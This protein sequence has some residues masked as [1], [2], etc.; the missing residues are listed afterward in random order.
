MVQF[1]LESD[2]TNEP[3]LLCTFKERLDTA[4]CQ[5]VEEELFNKMRET[6]IPVIF[7]LH[8]VDYIASAFLRI[9]LKAT[10]EVGSGNFSVINVHPN[11]KKVFKIAG[12]DKQISI[13]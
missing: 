8:D 4:N 7:D 13:T 9:C 1:N 2:I 12:F 3:N 5:R 11:V 6:K 10:K